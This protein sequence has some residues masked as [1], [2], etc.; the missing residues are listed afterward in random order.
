[1]ALS[2][3]KGNRLSQKYFLEYVERQEERHLQ[4]KVQNYVRLAALKR[5]GERTIAGA[6]R[7]GLPPP[8]FLPHPEDIILNPSTGEARVSDPETVE[9]LRFYEHMGQK[10]DFLL[11]CSAH[12][13]PSCGKRYR[14]SAGHQLPVFRVR[15]GV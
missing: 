10:C 13:N 8:E 14:K 7:R 3:L 1:M 15:A 11:L 4:Y 5:D 6:E 2:A 9:D 12:Y